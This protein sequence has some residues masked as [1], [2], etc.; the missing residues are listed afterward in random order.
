MPTVPKGLI[1]SVRVDVLDILLLES[2]VLDTVIALFFCGLP[3]SEN[4]VSHG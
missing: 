3:F 1:I 4:G 2:E